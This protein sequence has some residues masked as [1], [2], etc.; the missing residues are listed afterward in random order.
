MRSG[1]MMLNPDPQFFQSTRGRIVAALRRKVM[2]ADEL[3]RKL[4]QTN[5]TIRAQLRGMERDGVIEPAGLRPGVTRPFAVYRLTAEVERLLSRAYAPFLTRLVDV[6]ASR[7]T[8]KEFQTV[9]RETG[10]ALARDLAPPPNGRRALDERLAAATRLLDEELGAVT[11][12]EEDG[13]GVTIRGAA[14]PLAA[15][16]GK[17][18]GACLAIESLLGACL[19]VAVKECCERQER[20]R[21]CFRVATRRLRRTA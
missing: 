12:V 19:G 5:P 21:C 8:V 11:H 2:T 20:P 1:R 6:F 3:A 13:S 10:R 14:C 17:H 7:Q 15:V 4:G 9:M 18:P 16:T